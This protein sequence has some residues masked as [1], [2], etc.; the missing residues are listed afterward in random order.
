VLVAFAAGSLV[1]SAMFHMLPEAW[2]VGSPAA[3]FGVAVLGVVTFGLLESVLHERHHHDHEGHH[4]GVGWMLLAGDALHSLV[5]GIAVGSAF[6]V[7]VRLGL[8]V[9][10]AEIAHEVPQELGDYA[11]LVQSGMSHR[12]ALGLN[13]V[14]GL[15]FP[16]GGL[17]AILGLGGASVA[18]PLAFAAGN[19]LYLAWVDLIPDVVRRRNPGEI[20]AMVSGIGLL[21]ALALAI[22]H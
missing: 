14:A 19:F 5:G 8:A 15:G 13:L 17:V 20:V 3:V 22:P 9:W 10:L 18:W 12:R 1:G 7:D 16:I 6:L 4:H 21:A 2:G 11:V